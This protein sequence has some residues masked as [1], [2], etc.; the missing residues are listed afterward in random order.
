MNR[1]EGRSVKSDLVRSAHASKTRSCI[2]E[3]FKRQRFGDLCI[4]MGFMT[5][6]QLKSAMAK[7]EIAQERL[8]KICIREGL[9]DEEQLARVIAAQYDYAYTELD[10]IKDAELLKLAP[11]ELMSKYRFVPVEKRDNT[12][13]V[14]ISEPADFVR[15]LDSLEILFDMPIAVVIAS[16]ARIQGA[17]KKVE[18]DHNV[19]E[20]LSDDMRLPLVKESESGEVTLSLEKVSAEDSPIVRLV[21]STILDALNKKASDIHIESSDQGV[22]IRYR[23]DGM[24]HRITEP[25]HIHYQSPIISRIKVMSELDISEKR[26]PQDGRFKVKVK[27]RNI[28]FRVSIVP[29]IFGED[30]VIR[31]LDRETLMPDARE[32]RLENLQLPARQLSII[33]RLIR[34]PYGM[35]LVTGPTGS[36]KTT[37]L[38]TALSEVNNPNQK[39]I[40]I[41]DPVEYQLKG[42]AQ[43]QVNEKK[44]LTFAR[45]LRSILRHDPD[46]ILVGEIRDEETAQIALQSALTGH[47]VFTTVHAN[48]SFEVINRFI[49]MGIEPY[50]L[51][52]ALNCIIAQRLVRVLCDCKIAVSP[53]ELGTYLLDSEVDERQCGDRPVFRENELGCD[54]CKGSGFK[55][56]RAIMELIEMTDD[57]KEAFLQK[58]SITSFK[59]KAKE[60]GTTFLRQAAL[61]LVV[62]GVTSLGEANRVT[63]IESV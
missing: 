15:A 55:G 19:L 31:I 23:I 30:A 5:E 7:Q 50:D 21:D 43:I 27:D 63:F 36:G 35:F 25:L 60:A 34:A 39:I 14:A 61:E 17:L 18:S 38:Y 28:D 52:A 24:L 20:N 47:L 46:K 10:G 53:E 32:Y 1:N 51:V 2:E 57:M 44:G 54:I 4:Q 29:T 45:G 26:I 59:K 9:L 37:T 58:L 16:E 33:R 22:I 6:E 13:V 56:R 40:T 48:S 11:V 62:N 3:V 41:E 12:L 8:G 49:H 42:I